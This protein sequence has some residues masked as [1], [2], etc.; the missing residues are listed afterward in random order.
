MQS[1]RTGAG[2]A[3]LEQIEEGGDVD[4]LAVV[5]GVRLGQVEDQVR[6]AA[7]ETEQAFLAL[8]QVEEGLVPPLLER[9]EHLLAREF[10]HPLRL[11]RGRSLRFVLLARRNRRRTKRRGRG[12]AR[13]LVEDRDLQLSL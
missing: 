12:V 5:A 8:Q 1:V 6:R 3:H 9:L 2:V 13:T 11:A 10:G 7:R 4:V